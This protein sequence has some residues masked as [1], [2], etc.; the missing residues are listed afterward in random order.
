MSQASQITLFDTTLRDG[1]L[2]LTHELTVDQK[3]QIALLLD[4]AG[5][6]VTEVGYPGAFP[7]DLEAIARVAQQVNNAVICGLASS[8]LNE[9]EAVAT[10]LN[11]SARGRINAFTPIR[12]EQEKALSEVVETI[13]RVSL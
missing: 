3:L 8:H 12:V 5:A 4:E 10:A 1:E 2:A 11:P 6:D 13:Q 9:I 7:R